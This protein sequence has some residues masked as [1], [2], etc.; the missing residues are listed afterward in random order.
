MLDVGLKACYVQG[1]GTKAMEGHRHW[2]RAGR[3]MVW[4]GSGE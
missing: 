1:I 2:Q 3:I 4:T